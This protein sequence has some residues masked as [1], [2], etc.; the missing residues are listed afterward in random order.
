VPTIPSPLTRPT[1]FAQGSRVRYV[2]GR[3]AGTVASVPAID[4]AELDPFGVPTV[5][6][7]IMWDDEPGRAV[8]WKTWTLRPEPVASESLPEFGGCS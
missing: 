1:V 2:T 4:L 7:L 6:Q 8:P 5:M 3:R